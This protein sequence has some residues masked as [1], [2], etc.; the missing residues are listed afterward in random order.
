[1]SV[2][3]H[4][5]LSAETNL[6]LA[7]PFPF[8]EHIRYLRDTPEGA[9]QRVVE[10]DD[11]DQEESEDH[12]VLLCRVCSYTITSE[13]QSIEM[14]GS[15]RHT[16]FNPAGI[17][18]ELG[19]FAEASGVAL[20]GDASSDFSWFSGYAWRVAVCAKCGSHLGWQ[21]TGARAFYGLILKSLA[22]G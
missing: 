1:M 12:R 11:Q 2:T 16:F 21:F 13:K 7:E 9:E 6:S 14:N 22:Q 4:Q 19:C 10:V 20:F 15:H 18:F 17:V 3:P 5:I 8:P